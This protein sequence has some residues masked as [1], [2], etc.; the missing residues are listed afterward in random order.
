MFGTRVPR[1]SWSSVYNVTLTDI[2]RL[3]SHKKKYSGGVFFEPKKEKKKE[4]LNH[5]LK[6]GLRETHQVSFN[7][8]IIANASMCSSS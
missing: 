3:A 2:L 7:S 5:L 1:L 4:K 6:G 8:D